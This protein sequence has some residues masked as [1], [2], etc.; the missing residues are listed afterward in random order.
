VFLKLA[1]LGTTAS[2][3]RR[4]N[5]HLTLIVEKGNIVGLRLVASVW[6]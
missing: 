1:I 6:I 4:P 5:F 3:S 2:K